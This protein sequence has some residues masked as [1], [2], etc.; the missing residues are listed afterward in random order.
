VWDLL[1]FVVDILPDDGTLLS[2]IVE[3]GT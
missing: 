2:K 3:F 1:T